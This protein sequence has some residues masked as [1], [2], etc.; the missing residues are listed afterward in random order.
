MKKT[1]KLS[2]LATILLCS[3]LKSLAIDNTSTSNNIAPIN[4][5]IKKPEESLQQNLEKDVESLR[6]PQIPSKA[7]TPEEKIIEPQADTNPIIPTTAPTT[8]TS[9]KDLNFKEKIIKYYK[10]YEEWSRSK[11]PK[12]L[13]SLTEKYSKKTSDDKKKDEIKLATKPIITDS[14][15]AKVKTAKNK[16]DEP[17]KVKI[18]EN[19][20]SFKEKIIKYYKEYEEWTRGKQP[21][22]LVS[23][24]EKYSKKEAKTGDNVNKNN[25]HSKDLDSNKIIAGNNVSETP[26]NQINIINKNVIIDL[27]NIERKN[28]PEKANPINN[29]KV[30]STSA[31]LENPTNLAKA[32][33]PVLNKQENKIET[34]IPFQDVAATKPQETTT[35]LSSAMLPKQVNKEPVQEKPETQPEK[36]EVA[37]TKDKPK[38]S[39][40][41]EENKTKEIVESQPIAQAKNTPPA[42]EAV[43]A[44]AEEQMPGDVKDQMNNSTQNANL[45]PQ[46]SRPK[47]IVTELKKVQ[48]KVISPEELALQEE[49]QKEL[50]KF[51]E[52]EVAMLTFPRDEDLVLGKSTLSAKLTYADDTEYINYFWNFYNKNKNVAKNR[53]MRALITKL[54]KSDGDVKIDNVQEYAENYIYRNDIDGLRTLIDHSDINFVRYVDDGF[55]PVMLAIEQREYNSLY[56]LLMRGAPASRITPDGR[57]LYNI[58]QEGSSDSII[59]LLKS[60]S[61]KTN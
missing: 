50:E 3:S 14:S 7:T 28:L 26:S 54:S 1:L 5:D 6:A 53:E 38:D 12:W 30:P 18:S 33:E 11:Q 40:A 55:D 43:A 35:A 10:E 9:E 36:V 46:D 60:A 47:L 44:K 61:A 58:A 45:T 49:A 29:D 4:I 56:Y 39:V 27:P 15:D 23:L 13:V 8:K 59:W 48:Q 19:G 24:T 32:E 2:L 22:W 31:S 37:E 34:P 41:P 16:I 52:D 25:E 42:T 57:S 20:P 51:V 17:S 21:K